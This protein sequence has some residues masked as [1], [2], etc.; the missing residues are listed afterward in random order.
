M[1]CGMG[2]EL[3]LN[4]ELCRV[5]NSGEAGAQDSAL[6][7]AL[8]GAAVAPIALRLRL[9]RLEECARLCRAHQAR[10]TTYSEI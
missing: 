10:T 8:P 7:H 4:C 3:I 9:A 1:P 5:P 2:S 6:L